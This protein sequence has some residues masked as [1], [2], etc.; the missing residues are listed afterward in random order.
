M[1]PEQELTLDEAILQLLEEEDSKF[2]V[3]V[4]GLVLMLPRKSV[5]ATAEQVERRL[6]YLADPAIDFVSRIAASGAFHTERATWRI[7]ARGM[8]HLRG[9]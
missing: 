6:R 2:G 4:Q 7:S 9:A 8:N 5:R 1:T 3:N